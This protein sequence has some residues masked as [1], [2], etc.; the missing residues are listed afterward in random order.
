MILPLLVA[1]LTNQ[2]ACYCIYPAILCQFFLYRTDAALLK[3]FSLAA[4]MIVIIVCEIII[5]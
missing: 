5:A 4:V 1:V 3:N 2:N